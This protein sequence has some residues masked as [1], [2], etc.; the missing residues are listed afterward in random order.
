[1]GVRFFLFGDESV[2]TLNELYSSL[3]SR[4][5]Y[6]A[7]FLRLGLAD[8]GGAWWF[9]YLLTN[10]GRGG[11][12]GDPRG[13]PVQVWAT[14]F[15]RDGKPQSFIQGL[16]LEGLDLSARMQN[17]FHFRIGNNEVGFGIPGSAIAPVDDAVIAPVNRGLNHGVRNV[18]LQR[19]NKIACAA[20]G[21]AVGQHAS[22]V[23]L[24]DAL[25]NGFGSVENSSTGGG[26]A[27]GR[28]KRDDR[29]DSPRSLARNRARD[30][31]TEAVTDQ[32]NFP[33]GLGQ[34]SLVT[35]L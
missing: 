8:D 2:K 28:G 31:A 19:I 4:R 6:E 3:S 15:P 23:L 10:P 27:N 20:P 1:M 17:P 35:R 34:R 29:S 14:W 7:W 33:P 21:V 9:R 30:H 12:A 22:A 25:A 5:R 26:A 24:Q 11:C 18:A 16:P 32:V 13:M